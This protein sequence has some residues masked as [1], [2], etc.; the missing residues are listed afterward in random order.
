[1]LRF[2]GRC[3]FYLVQLTAKLV[4]KY[5]PTP[6]PEYEMSSAANDNIDFSQYEG[7]VEC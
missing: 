3:L 2:I 7:I 5:D 4:E 6:E 1:M